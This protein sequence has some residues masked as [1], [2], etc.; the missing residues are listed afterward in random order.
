M[1]NLIPFSKSD[2][3]KYKDHYLQNWTLNDD[4]LYSLCQ[5]NYSHDSKNHI[6][7][8]LWI[9]GRTYATGIERKIKT[10]RYQG[11]SLS[12]LARHLYE[13]RDKVN[14]I[15]DKL[16]KITSVSLLTV[17]KL[18]KIVALHGEFSHLI[19]DITRENQ[20][21]RSFVSKYMHFHCPV[22]P[23]YDGFASRTLERF[24]RR[25]DS[26]KVFI[27]P[28]IADDDY[29]WFVLRFWGLYQKASKVV[30]VEKVKHLDYYLLCVADKLKETGR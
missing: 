1:K 7:A 16:S 18:E 15:F 9:I 28:V 19:K 8:K 27:K 2:Y 4:T 22:V 11:G 12:Q 30:D 26:L 17:Q 29:Y 20:S 10:N 6:N 13:N 5:K 3:Q 14:A 23:I 24:Q 21:P 25:D